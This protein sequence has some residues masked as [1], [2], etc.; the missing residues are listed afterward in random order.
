MTNNHKHTLFITSCGS[1]T[2]LCNA[3]LASDL[4]RTCLLG[5]TGTVVS[6]LVTLLLKRLFRRWR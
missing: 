4:L 6:F 1:I 5:A 2:G 3:I